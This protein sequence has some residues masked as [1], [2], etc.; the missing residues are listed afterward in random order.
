MPKILTLEHPIVSNEGKQMLTVEVGYS[1]DGT[2][3]WALYRLEFWNKIENRWD[4]NRIR[5][6]IYP[7]SDQSPLDVISE[8]FRVFRVDIAKLTN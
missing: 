5:S 8:I 3:I 1:H 6:E 2:R 4:K 7:L